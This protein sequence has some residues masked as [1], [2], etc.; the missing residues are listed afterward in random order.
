M[1]SSGRRET[2]EAIAEAK[3]RES[4]AKVENDL[5]QALNN[6]TFPTAGPGKF[7]YCTITYILYM[8]DFIFYMLTINKNRTV[9]VC[10]CVCFL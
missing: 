9:G 5:N 7:Q 3:L 10:V 8:S 2:A 1:S 4:I 6:A